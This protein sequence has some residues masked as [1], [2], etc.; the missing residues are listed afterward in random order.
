MRWKGLEESDDENTYEPEPQL[1]R[2]QSL[3]L[4]QE[5]KISTFI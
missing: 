4:E 1:I 3:R 5:R 2:A